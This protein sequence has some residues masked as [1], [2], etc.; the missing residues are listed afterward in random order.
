MMR[1][2]IIA[3]VLALTSLSA[4]FAQDFS[5]EQRAACK[6][7]FEKFCKGTIPGG[8]RVLACL[9]KQHDSLSGACKKAVEAQKK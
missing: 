1:T 5:A 8:G 6:G 9:D 4:A 7:D 3:A 2:M